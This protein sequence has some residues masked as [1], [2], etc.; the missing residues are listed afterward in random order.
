[1]AAAGGKS[2]KKW[3]I[4]A[5][6]S[7]VVLGLIFWFLPFGAVVDGFSRV[8]A[9]LFPMVV[10]LFLL[11]HAVTAAKW[12]LLIDRGIPLPVALQAHFAGLA[13][14]LALPGAAGGDAVRAGF[15]Q[16]HMRDGARV[17]AGAVADRLIDTLGL[18]CLS[19]A[20]L[21]LLHG[22]GG[23]AGRAAQAAVIVL[24]LVAV[25]VFAFP[26]IV[27]R[28]WHRFPKLPARGLALR[29]ADAFTSLGRRPGLLAASLIISMAVQVLF[30]GLSMELGRA[31]GV[32]VPFAVWLFAWPLAKIIAVLPVSLG[33]L[34]VREASLAALM[35]PFGADA[36][37]VVASGL[38]WQAVL[39][40]SGAIGAT[41]LA[42]SG[43]RLKRTA[44]VDE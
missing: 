23:G 26:G 1:M 5:A 3:A 32:D 9:T 18:A 11:G 8:P 29:T 34:G 30:I 41:V 14:N 37:Q 42:L 4:R 15:A 35:T 6:G 25:A 21:A 16:L 10:L 7:A 39:Y 24:V 38:V 2:M 28:L 19:V 17:A 44:T 40:I 13:A 22:Q 27:A 33:G 43:V 36:A 31:V 20:G 12:W